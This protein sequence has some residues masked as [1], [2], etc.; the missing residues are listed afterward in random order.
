MRAVRKQLQFQVPFSHG[1]GIGN[2]EDI[3]EQGFGETLSPGTGVFNFSGQFQVDFS[4]RQVPVG[5]DLGPRYAPGGKIPDFP[6]KFRPELRQVGFPDGQAGSHCMTSELL[7]QVGMCRRQRFQCIF[8]VNPGYRTSGPLEQTFTGRGKYDYRPVDPLFYPAGQHADYALAPA[9][10]KQAYAEGQLTLLQFGYI[11]QIRLGLFL[12]FGLELFSLL[13]EFIQLQRQ[14]NGAGKIVREQAFDA[15]PHVGHAAGR[16]QPRTQLKPEV[17]GSNLLRRP[18]GSPDQGHDALATAPRPDTPQALVNQDTVVVVQLHHVGNS[19]QRHQVQ[20]C[21][22]VRR[23]NALRSKPACM[24]QPGPDCQQH[25]K[26]DAHTGNTLAW[27][28]VA[29]LVRVDDDGGGRKLPARQMMI[30]NQDIHSRA[31]GE[32]DAGHTGNTVVHGHQEVGVELQGL[33]R[34]VDTQAISVLYPV[35]NHVDDLPGAQHGQPAQG[36]GAGRC[37]VCVIIRHDQDF[38]IVANGI[39]KQ[40]R[41]RVKIFQFVERQQVGQRIIQFPMR[42]NIPAGKD[43][44]HDRMH[45]IRQFALG[46]YVAAGDFHSAFSKDDPFHGFQVGRNLLHRGGALPHGDIRV[47]QAVSGQGA[48]HCAALRD[49]SGPDIVQG[50]GYG[51]G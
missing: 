9:R 25:V 29:G 31:P 32:I 2:G 20:Q 12:H 36:H 4:R 37:S 45:G 24:L 1:P 6:V 35:R 30:R 22:E 10:I 47:F 28:P 41:R 51:D 27:E 19:A 21:R 7:H 16:V 44:A 33:A 15:Q 5:D 3:V 14:G 40:S 50:A 23:L 46:M 43:P 49:F 17:G 8:Q 11:E 38:F 13:V 18:A 34:H 26:H 39:D 42:R 48:N